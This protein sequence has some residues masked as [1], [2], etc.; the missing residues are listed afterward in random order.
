MGGEGKTA[1]CHRKQ[2]QDPKP[3][4]PNPEG[5]TASHPSSL[6]VSTHCTPRE[7]HDPFLKNIFLSS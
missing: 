7:A 2:E 3:P 1:I 4:I 5:L 6:D